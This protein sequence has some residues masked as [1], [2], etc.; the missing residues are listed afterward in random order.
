MCGIA[1]V[2]NESLSEKAAHDR[3]LATLDRLR[4]RGDCEPRALNGKGF[5]LGC[6]RLAIVDRDHGHQPLASDGN[7]IAVVYNGEIYNHKEL[8]AELLSHGR[9]FRTACDTEILVQGYLQWGSDL[10]KR[11]RGMFAFLVY[12]D[13]TREFLAARDRLGIKPLYYEQDGQNWTFASEI[14]ALLS[15]DRGNAHRIQSLPPGSIAVRTGIQQGAWL[16]RNEVIPPEFKQACAHL[17]E[18]LGES[19]AGMLDTDLPVAILVSGGIDSS[20]LLYE[21]VQHFRNHGRDLGNLRPYCVGVNA[22]PGAEDWPDLRFAKLAAEALN[23]ELSI[24][25]ISVGEM[26]NSVRDV[27]SIM[28]SFEP[29]HIRAGTAHFALTQRLKR[30]GIKV[31]LC[32]EGADELL[33]G[34]QEF[35]YCAQ[36]HGYSNRLRELFRQFVGELHKTQLQRVDRL[37]MACGIEARVPY[38]DDPV[39]DFLWSLPDEWKVHR[40]AAGRCIGKYVLRESYRGLLPDAIVDRR[41]VPMGEGAGVGDNGPKGP[42][43]TKAAEIIGSE[44]LAY[45]QKKYPKFDLKN[46]EEA[47]YFRTFLD[48]FGELSLATE[49]PHTNVMATQ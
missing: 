27:I 19:V 25:N 29:N 8:R 6:V 32:G 21:A 48:K 45:Y 18:L 16:P 15:P 33:G 42:F 10:V 35:P 46:K 34:Y 12:D 26:V 30:D 41:K 49:R 22:T 31:L 44:S 40:D 11:L 5:S 17:R 47:W 3:L 1:G 43:F 13:E 2:F 7:R 38:L 24:E 20:I 23:V 28:E 36:V 37:S 4:H 9:I 39:A 14:K